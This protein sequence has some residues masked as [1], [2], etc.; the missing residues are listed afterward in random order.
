MDGLEPQP[1]L[2]D[3]VECKGHRTTNF[4][5]CSSGLPWLPQGSQWKRQPGQSVVWDRPQ[6]CVG[7]GLLGPQDSGCVPLFPSPCSVTSGWQLEVG[8][9]GSMSMMDS[10]LPPPSPPAAHTGEVLLK[11]L[12]MCHWPCLVSPT[13]LKPPQGRDIFLQGWGPDP[14]A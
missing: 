12:A 11:H 5:R 10:S 9:D 14:R 3:W 2:R 4:R 7:P 13:Q 6:C 1:K 8:K